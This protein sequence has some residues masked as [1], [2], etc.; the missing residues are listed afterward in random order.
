[1]NEAERVALVDRARPLVAEG[2]PRRPRRRGARPGDLPRRRHEEPTGDYLGAVAKDLWRYVDDDAGAPP[3][4]SG[5]DQGDID[6]NQRLAGVEEYNRTAVEAYYGSYRTTVRSATDTLT[7]VQHV[8]RIHGGIVLASVVLAGL[9]LL[10]ARGTQRAHLVLFAATAIAVASA[11]VATAIYN[12]RYIVPVL[13]TLIT[14]GAMATDVLWDRC[15][16]PSRSSE[17]QDRSLHMPRSAADDE[18]AVERL[19]A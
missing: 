2:A 11:P 17:A 9:A 3:R 16:R 14:A 10:F 15:R 19:P 7:S 8:L 18:G 6:L 12:W 1:M 5:Y 4:Y 13:P